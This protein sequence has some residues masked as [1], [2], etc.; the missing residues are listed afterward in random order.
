MSP[1]S[2]LPLSA[3]LN[4]TME[5]ENTVEHKILI[6]RLLKARFSITVP[7]LGFRWLMLNTHL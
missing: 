7:K 1:F 3:L 5:Q 6:Y 2:A 4:N